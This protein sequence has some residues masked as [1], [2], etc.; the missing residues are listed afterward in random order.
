VHSCAVGLVLDAQTRGEPVAW[1]AVGGS[2]FYPPDL[3]DS[4][5]DLDALVVVRVR[6][7][8]TGAR[9][10]ERL[11]RSGAFGLVVIDAAG[12]G[13]RDKP[14]S[15]APVPMGH[16]GRLQTIAQQHDAAVVVLTDKPRTAPSLG[17]II[18]LRVN[19]VREGGVADKP[20]G[21]KIDAAKDK[22]RGPWSLIG[23]RMRPPAGLR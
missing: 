10:A 4:G 12:P 7:L 17:S 22:R 18:S 2:T 14:A 21:Y 20:Y 11:L 13:E 15:D 3:D 8:V 16:L 1:I 6:D 19:A 23:A 9:A 5:V